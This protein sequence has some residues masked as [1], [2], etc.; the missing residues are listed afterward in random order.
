MASLEKQV[1][2]V[3][4]CST[5]IGR[6]LVRELA[7]R[8]H[9]P[10][11]TARRL[12]AIADLAADG[13]E[14]LRLDVRDRGSI[15]AAVSAVHDR[16]GRIDV[17]VNNAGQNAFGP[18]LELP[19][20]KVRSLLET[21]VLGLL[22]VSQAVFP[23]MADRGAGLLVNVGSVVGLLPTPFAGG[24][25]ASKSAV[26]MLSEV[27][28]MEV[29]PFGIGV[30]VVQPGGVKSSIADNAADDIERFRAESSRY[31]R[32]YDG[33]RKRAYASQDGPMPAEDFARELVAQALV[34]EPPRVI[35]LGTGSDV[36]PRL[37]E[38][39]GEQ[40]DAMLSGTYG[41]A[42]LRRPT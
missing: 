4:G 11:A 32:A 17:L 12:E 13:I 27:M 42:A 21:N 22:S 30:V 15:D 23:G 34:T 16:A 26:H 33:I 38:L 20:E 6:A 36:L 10:F 35:R 19:L 1:V 37:A 25:C 2:L 8:G 18:V 31:H 5:G 29:S 41:L 39:P 9:R 24:Y 40:R 3:T 14:T 28:R 7:A